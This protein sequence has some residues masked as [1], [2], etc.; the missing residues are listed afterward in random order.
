M[1]KGLH[2]IERKSSPPH[3]SIRWI[4]LV[5]IAF[6][7]LFYKKLRTTLTIMAVVIGVGAVV[8]L[9]AF[10][11]GLKDLVT[12]QV[13]DSNSI[14]TIDVESA[15]SQLVKLDQAT[16]EKVKN[17]SGVEKVAKMYNVAGTTSFNNS[18][19][20]SVLYG[21]DQTYLD[22]S[23]LKVA[24]GSP[25]R[26]SDVNQ[27]F[28]NVSYA[29]AVGIDKTAEIVGKKLS[30]SFPLPKKSK[31]N[32]D[33]SETKAKLEV[34]VLGV[35]ET[36][37]GAEVYVPSQ[38]FENAGYV[39]ANQLK[40]L[41]DSK[42]NVPKVQSSVETL[43]LVT[44]SPLNTLEQINQVFVFLNLL[45]LAFGGIGLIIAVLGMFNTLT[46]SLLERTKE[47]GLM[48]TLGARRKDVRRLFMVE[49]VGLSLIGGICGMGVS[50]LGSRIIDF[51]LSG[52]AR[53][54]GVQESFTIFA[55][56]P[57]LIM[58]VLIFSALLGLIVVYLPAKRAADTNPINALKS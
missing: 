50:Y 54:R 29:K 55:F 44:N 41:V 42:A 7:N 28:V 58:A 11:F 49:A 31:T 53:G 18:N 48:I 24:A 51:V 8:F 25:P 57:T 21:V 46:I 3:G 9:L 27:A 20:E 17:T 10:G 6:K 30:L 32:K 52:F 16:V 2:K 5:E 45:F 43:G 1:S 37:S 47:I 23:T 26:F 35:L 13:V 33:D 34:N 12:R 22:L 56:K 36:G 38:I 4:L 19:I 39:S 15:K 40:V 14:R